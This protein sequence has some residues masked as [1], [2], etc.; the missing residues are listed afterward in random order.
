MKRYFLL[1]VFALAFGQKPYAQT[2]NNEAGEEVV[3]KFK[4][5]LMQ[6]G[7][8]NEYQ[9]LVTLGSGMVYE[10]STKQAIILHDGDIKES[11]YSFV[12]SDSLDVLEPS[13]QVG[14]YGNKKGEGKLEMKVYR[15]GELIDTQNVFLKPENSGQVENYKWSYKAKKK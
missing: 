6:T 12:S 5:E 2:A 4:I 10:G 7:K 9:R 14:W 1:S 13:V 11:K 8:Y 15:N 3:A